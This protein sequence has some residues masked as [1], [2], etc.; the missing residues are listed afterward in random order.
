MLNYDKEASPLYYQVKQIIKE[1]IENGEYAL[2]NILLSEAKFQEIY[3]A[4]VEQQL[5]KQ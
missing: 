1:K 3:S 4:L 5:D 2:G